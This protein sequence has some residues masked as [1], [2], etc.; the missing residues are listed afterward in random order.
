MAHDCF[1][2]YS[3]QDKATADAAC[4]TL[5]AAGIR[6]WIAPRDILPGMNWGGSI[7]KAI[8]DAAVMVLIFS[9]N[10]NASEQVTR[11]VERASSKG[12]PIIPF[13]IE[14]IAPS[15]DLEYFISTP[16]W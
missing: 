9:G 8:G 15:P 2:S 12:V 10:S 6:C 1:I 7:I 3:T 4:A 5:E 11:E 13:R 16:H 14:A